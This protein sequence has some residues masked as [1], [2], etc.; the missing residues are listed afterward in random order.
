MLDVVAKLKK[1]K[2]VTL[3]W[4]AAILVSSNFGLKTESGNKNGKQTFT[5][6]AILCEFLLFF[7]SFCKLNT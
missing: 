2:H 4:F 1:K 6:K 7:H 3:G 5:T